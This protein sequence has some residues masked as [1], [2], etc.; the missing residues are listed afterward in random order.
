[1]HA[2]D[3]AL[4]G[5]LWMV[6]SGL[7]FVAVTAMVK[8]VGADVPAAQ[9]AFLRYALG[10]VFVLPLLRPVLAVRMAGRDLALFGL[11]GALHAAAVIAWFF[12][13]TRIPIAEVT[14][15]NY[16][17]PVYVTLG[18]ALFLGERIGPR[19]I[20]AVAAALLGALV[21]LRP[22]F[23]ELSP[24]HLSMIFAALFF[25]CSY[26][27][28][29]RLSAMAEAGIVVALLSL[30]VTLLLAP[31]AALDWRPVGRADLG[32]LFLTAAAATLGHY[33]MTRAFA[34]APVT[35]TQPVTF[36]QL[37]WS[38]ALGA[39]F[40]GEGVDLYVIAGGALIVAAV[41]YTA[42]REGKPRPEPPA[43]PPS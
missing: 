17:S 11:R 37:I 20:A 8:H 32:W 24:G 41:A 6:L 16:M 26:L 2:R 25:A 43:L 21:I 33:A 3:A 30:I 12:A 10:L 34:A 15:M 27:I 42:W 4:A 14:A 19:R 7:C 36:L 29:K 5:L 31:A 40:F 18:A 9:A 28:A 38:V 23:R 35:V 13:M 22:G 39:L 1:M